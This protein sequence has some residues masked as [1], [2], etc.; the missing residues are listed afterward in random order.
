MLCRRA[1]LPREQA[2]ALV[3]LL[4][5]G[6]RRGEVEYEEKKSPSIL[7]RFPIVRGW[8]SVAAGLPERPAFAVIWTTTPWTIPAN[9]AIA[10][11]PE[12]TYAIVESDGEYYLVA[13][14]LAAAVLKEAGRERWVVVREV[15]GAD[16]EGLVA[17]HPY[18]GRESRFVL[19]DHVTLEA[20]SGLVHTAPGHGQEDYVV[21]QRY[22]LEVYSPVDA[23]GAL[24]PMWSSWP[25][26]R[27]STPT[28]PSSRP[29]ARPET[30]CTR[31]RSPTATRTAGAASSR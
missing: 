17:R 2:G 24:P 1:R 14:E 28:P 13:K 23:A 18:L 15:R 11:H 26:R 22:G 3:H 5:H 7:V 25:A 31:G 10:A 12:F 9:L 6:A 4:P 8:Q 29:S 27:S 30:S 16:L 19:G 21:G 20:G